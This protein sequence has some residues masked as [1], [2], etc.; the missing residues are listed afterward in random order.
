MGSSSSRH[1][2]RPEEQLQHNSGHAYAPSSVQQ[3][4]Q[5]P[6]P[7]FGGST[8]GQLYGGY[9]HQ[10]PYG[11]M[12]PM[13]APNG[14]Y[15]Q[16]P[17]PPLT[18]EYQ[19]TQTI[20]NQVNLRKKTLRLQPVAGSNT[21]F[22]LEFSFDAST[23][24]RVSTFLLATEDPRQSCRI[25][26]AA[27][28]PRP[29]AF[30]AKGMDQHFPKDDSI[31]QQHMISLT[32]HSPD[33]LTLARGDSYPLIIRLE[34]LT[35]QAAAEGKQLQQLELGAA[36]P[37]WIQAQTTYA[38]LKKDDEGHWGLQIIKQKIWVGGTSY[39][40]QEIYGMDSKLNAS[41]PEEGGEGRECVIC[42]SAE[43][44]TTVL[45]CR[46]MCMCQQCASALRTQTN[47]C[48]ICREEIGSLLHIKIQHK[49]LTD[50]TPGLT[51]SSSVGSQP[52]LQQIAK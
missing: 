36:L 27:S 17:R 22:Q 8:N 33:L 39:E 9:H 20:K 32:T 21:E 19:Q 46:H 29:P 31:A 43:R 41:S 26:A 23:P 40:L 34:T 11:N 50:L 12:P 15:G 24:C 52:G 49:G 18:H 37:L 42:M 10:A 28:E 35:E 3:S 45:P 6:T 25:I 16:P 14:H 38:K 48:P 2:P 1:R 13:Y 4:P 51:P 44:D 7:N 5:Y 30:Y 47:K